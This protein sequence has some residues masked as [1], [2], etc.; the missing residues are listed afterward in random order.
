M[1]AREST[2]TK[3]PP[4]FTT[5]KT[6]RPDLTPHS[7]S[8]FEILEKSSSDVGPWKD[9][10]TKRKSMRARSAIPPRTAAP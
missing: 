3:P 6:I 9:L 10:R 7:S 1:N 5:R 4:L 8:T 2:G